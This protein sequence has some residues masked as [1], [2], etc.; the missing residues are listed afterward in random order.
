MRAHTDALAGRGTRVIET[1]LAALTGYLDVLDG[2]R[3]SGFARLRSALEETSDG[4]HAPGQR[5]CLARLL[6]EACAAAEDPEAGVAATGVLLGGT[7]LVWKA[8]ALRLR[9]EFRAV[10]GTDDVAGDLRSALLV[11]RRQRARS[12]ELRVA[13]SLFR[14]HRDDEARAL[15]VAALAALPERGQTPDSTEAEALLARG[16]LAERPPAHPAA[17]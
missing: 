1:M 12:L 13:A 7:A 4:E 3:K 14:H 11:A 15:L 8:E 5:A 16:T 9:A 2:R 17:P 6:V 10:L